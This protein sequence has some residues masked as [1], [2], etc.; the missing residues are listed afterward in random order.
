MLNRCHKSNFTVHK[1]V[2]RICKRVYAT[3]YIEDLVCVKHVECN[4]PYRTRFAFNEW[5]YCMIN[6]FSF[7]YFYFLQRSF[8]MI[9]SL[10]PSDAYMRPK[11]A[12]SVQIMA[13]RLDGA[14]PLSEPMLEYCCLDTWDQTSVKSQSK[15][16]R[17]HSKNT[18][19]TI[20]CEMAAILS[21][22]Q[23]VIRRVRKLEILNN[24]VSAP[25]AI[26]M[27]VHIDQVISS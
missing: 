14:K 15:L 2:T 17:F 13:S 4:Q 5:Y 22:P 24:R 23:Y 27:L 8:F 25:F 26:S 19:E 9:I 12:S 6:W 16:I 11:T 18:F 7:I 20:V 21:R 1:Y 3:I 10:R